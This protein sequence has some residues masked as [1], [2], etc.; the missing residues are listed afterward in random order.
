MTTELRHTDSVRRSILENW[1]LSFRNESASAMGNV[2]AREL[3]MKETDD[4]DDFFQVKVRGESIGR[5][6]K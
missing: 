3:N 5:N 6:W 1:G 2:G 4:E